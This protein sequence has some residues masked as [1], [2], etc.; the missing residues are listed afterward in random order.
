LG[1][2][3]PALAL[4]SKQA[5]LQQWRR[6][7]SLV[8]A[9]AE[10]GWAGERVG[11]PLLM[12]KGPLLGHRFYGDVAARAM[13]DLDM[14]VRS[15]QDLSLAERVLQELGYTPAFRLLVNRRA[16]RSFTHHFL[17]RRGDLAIELHWTF[18]RHPAFRVDYPRVW[19]T[20]VSVPFQG[21][22]YLALATEYELA[23]RIIGSL[24]DFQV[25]TLN[26]RPL[27]DMY[28]ILTSAGEPDWPAF[29]RQRQREGLLRASVFFLSLMLDV[30]DCRAIFPALAAFLRPWQQRLPI[31][32]AT[33]WL[34][35]L[36]S[37]PN[38]WRQ[39]LAALS[40]YDSPLPVALG[41]WAVSLPF[42]L[43]VYQDR[44][45]RTLAAT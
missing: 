1:A 12:L 21:R 34:G 43:A 25:G 26:L 37:Q 7:E 36:D 2:L 33:G 28:V 40:L 15:E 41:W 38:S 11:L 20:A 5:Y 18:Q 8:R 42:R 39:K 17:Y 23:L 24:T 3:P 19:G 31:P 45:S 14:L 16:S 6:S 44:L 22:P 32:L 10:I 13:S 29:F 4:S 30:L 35:A 27:L 9:M